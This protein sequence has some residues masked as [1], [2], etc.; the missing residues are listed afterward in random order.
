[1]VSYSNLF[2]VIFFVLGSTALSSAKIEEQVNP[3]AWNCWESQE[4][5][6]ESL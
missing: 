1:M 4:E 2:L 6:E 3:K 5:G